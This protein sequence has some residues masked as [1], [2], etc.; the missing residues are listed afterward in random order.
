ML[1]PEV[2]HSPLSSGE[3][4]NESI[5][6]STPLIPFL[7]ADRKKLPLTSAA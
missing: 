4:K 1:G 3:V 5:Y 6:I 7:G 2:N